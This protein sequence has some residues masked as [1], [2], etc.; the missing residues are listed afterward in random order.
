MGNSDIVADVIIKQ[1]T[2]D[3]YQ[4]IDK[5]KNIDINKLIRLL[6][7][8]YGSSVEGFIDDFLEKASHGG[9]K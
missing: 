4:P 3:F 6:Q 8:K 1:K 9:K 7:I 2:G 5:H